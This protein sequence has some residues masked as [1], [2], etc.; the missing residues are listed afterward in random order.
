[1]L[2][3]KYCKV[4][5]KGITN[6]LIEQVGRGD[7]LIKKIIY[8]SMSI[9]FYIIYFI[10]LR[11]IWN[12]FVQYNAITQIIAFF[13]L[14]FINIPLSVICTEKIFEEISRE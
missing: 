4:L 10:I 13:I 8:L 11:F 2:L 3:I 5:G 6:I 1:M 12:E 9:G 14:I 7:I